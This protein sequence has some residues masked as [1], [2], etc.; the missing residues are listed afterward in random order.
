MAFYGAHCALGIKAALCL[1]V[2][3][4][5]D[6]GQG[7]AYIPKGLGRGS[8]W[9][10]FGW[11]GCGLRANGLAGLAGSA[12]SRALGRETTPQN[13]KNPKTSNGQP[14]TKPAQQ[15]N[16]PAPPDRAHPQPNQP[17]PHQAP[18]TP[19]GIYAGPC[20]TPKRFPKQCAADSPRLCATHAK[21]PLRKFRKSPKKSG[22][23]SP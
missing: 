18:P 14:K 20:P 16:P 15:P 6:K 5:R 12:A 10:G 1:G 8:A 22:D 11:F 23:P 4:W 13:Q 21:R 7:L 2:V 19:L 3:F 9:W 17:K